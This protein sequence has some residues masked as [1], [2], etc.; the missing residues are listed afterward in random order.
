M[1]VDSILGYSFLW[2]R[3]GKPAYVSPD[4]EVPSPP[5]RHPR[6]RG[7]RETQSN[8]KS[9]AGLHGENRRFL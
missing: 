1:V 9:A 7:V 2:K 4:G 8:N 3:Q 6:P 5:R